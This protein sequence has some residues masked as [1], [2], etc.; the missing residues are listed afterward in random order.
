MPVAS[1]LS[2]L[3]RAGSAGALCV[4]VTAAGVGWL[5]LLRHVAPA[6]P[7]LRLQGA[8]P[9]QHLAGGDAQPLLRVVLAWLP[10]GVAAGAGLQA[11]TGLSRLGRAG[12]A[13]AAVLVVLAATGAV[14][15]AITANEPLRLHLASQARHDALWVSAAL[16]AAGALTVP[17]RRPRGRRS[18]PRQDAMRSSAAGRVAA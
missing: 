12:V 15:D 16:V 4:A 1:G 13:A 8:L 17:L 9:L 6:G 5:Y 18:A 14:S 10:A 11:L 3:L 2:R 7:G